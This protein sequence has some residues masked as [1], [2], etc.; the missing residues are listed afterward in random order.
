MAC[1][2]FSRTA[3]RAQKFPRV[4]FLHDE[5]VGERRD[6][7]GIAPACSLLRYAMRSGNFWRY[8][9]V[10]S[11][12]VTGDVVW[13]GDAAWC[14]LAWRSMAIRR[15]ELWQCDVAC[16]GDVAWCAQAMRRGVPW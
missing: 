8:G 11:G 13:A 1:V 15:D 16:F 10:C 2:E 14:A 12:E 5:W 9:V 7:S 4:P 6:V 3:L